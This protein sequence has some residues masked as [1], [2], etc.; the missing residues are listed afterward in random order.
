MT[1]LLSLI[2]GDGTADAAYDNPRWQDFPGNENC[3]EPRITNADYFHK[4]L[5]NLKVIFLVRNPVERYSMSR[6]QIIHVSL[7]SFYGE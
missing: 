2:L 3:V 5:P 1:S 6:E 7:A 4:L